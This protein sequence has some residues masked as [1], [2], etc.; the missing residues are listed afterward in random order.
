MKRGL[1]FILLGL[2]ICLSW[3]VSAASFNIGAQIPQATDVN[4]TITKYDSKGTESSSDDRPMGT[5]NSMDFGKLEYK[6]I[7]G[8]DGKKY[9]MFLT[10]YYFGVDVGV[11]GAAPWTIYHYVDGNDFRTTGDGGLGENIV[12]T[13]VKQTSDTQGTKLAGYTIADS[14]GKSF[15]ST[16]LSGG[17]LRI[18]YG[19]ATGAS[20]EPTGAKPIGLTETA[21]T[22]S[23]TIVITL[24]PR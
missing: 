1:F 24:T 21:K 4:V 14:Y 20:G 7:T 2:F 13:F 9:S 8:S 19:I 18:Y 5:V 11:N 22:Y 23:G 15:S 3:E 10:N 16:T 12:V 6:T 17:W